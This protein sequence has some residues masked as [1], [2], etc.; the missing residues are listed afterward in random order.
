MV[1]NFW[2]STSSYFDFV[3]RSIFGSR[4][5]QTAAQCGEIKTNEICMRN[6]VKTH[7]AT[8]LYIIYVHRYY[9]IVLA[10][11]V[12]ARVRVLSLCVDSLNRNT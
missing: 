11:A 1:F 12:Y 4:E 7:N 3:Q 2:I 6:T 10:E 5:Q 9:A 8:Q